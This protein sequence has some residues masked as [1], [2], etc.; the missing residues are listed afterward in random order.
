M[1]NGAIMVV[2]LTWKSIPAF[3][4]ASTLFFGVGCASTQSDASAEERVGNARSERHSATGS[5]MVLHVYRSLDSEG[6]S[7][8]MM[9]RALAAARVARRG[10]VEG[11]IVVLFDVPKDDR[12]LYS[13]TDKPWALDE[14]IRRYREDWDIDIELV[15]REPRDGGELE[16][17]RAADRLERERLVDGLVTVDDP[18]RRL[19][20]LQ[21]SGH[22]YVPF[23]E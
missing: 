16:A 22:V 20:E 9:L 11:P 17:R 19:W 18:V 2:K 6:P 1:K 13:R 10:G 12:W 14:Q 21:A 8:R 23:F 4:L 15:W 5:G 7:W 3:V